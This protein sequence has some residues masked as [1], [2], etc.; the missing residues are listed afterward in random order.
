ME[1]ISVFQKGNYLNEYFQSIF[2]KKFTEHGNINLLERSIDVMKPLELQVGRIS[3]LVLEFRANKVTGTYVV[4]FFLYN[5]FRKGYLSIQ[6]LMT[7]AIT[8]VHKSEKKNN[9]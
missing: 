9:I 8:P 3:K 4:A 1:V 6:H 5:L 2:S 7:R